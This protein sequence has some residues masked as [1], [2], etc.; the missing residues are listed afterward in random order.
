MIGDYPED[1][2]TDGE[3][4]I[5]W[6]DVGLARPTAQLQAFDDSWHLLAQMGAFLFSELEENMIPEDVVRAL[7]SEGFEDLTAYERL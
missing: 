1:G 4:A 7:K 2:G 3:F 6:V 5:R